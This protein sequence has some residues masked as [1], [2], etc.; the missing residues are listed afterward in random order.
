MITRLTKGQAP[1]LVDT[2]KANEVIDTINALLRTKGG[3]G[4]KVDEDQDG[5][6]I[7]SIDEKAS[8]RRSIAPFAITNITEDFVSVNAGTINNELATPVGGVSFNSKTSVQYLVLDVT[9]NN[10][11]NVTN[12]ELKVDGSAPDSFELEKNK[13]PGNFKLLIATITDLSFQQLWTGNIIAN[14]TARYSI[15]KES[16]DIGEYDHDIYYSWSVISTGA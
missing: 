8:S 5:A 15:P 16:V 12:A 6:L 2:E 7:I 13:A 4:I 9:V 1:S 14:P 3:E 10:V 11:G